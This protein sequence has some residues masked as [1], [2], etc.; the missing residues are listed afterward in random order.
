MPLLIR[1]E[2]RVLQ[3]CEF[4]I[5]FAIAAPGCEEHSWGCFTDAVM[6]QEFDLTR[7]GGGLRLLHQ[8]LMGV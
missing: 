1:E 8:F 2:W 6:Q 5:A 3:E 4:K 7:G